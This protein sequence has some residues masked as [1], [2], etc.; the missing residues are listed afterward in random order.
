MLNAIA[1]EEA[2]KALILLDV[3]RAG[4]RN[5]RVAAKQLRRYSD[6]LARC[7]YVELVA[8][9]PA[10]FR[11]V[12]DLVETHRVDYFLDGP[13]D[14]DW[15]FRNHLLE[16]REQIIYVDYVHT[17]EGDEWR[18]PASFDDMSF[19]L[20]SDA[21]DL[22]ASL[23]SLG[24]LTRPGLDAI[25]DAWDGMTLDDDTHWQAVRACNVAVVEAANARSR[26]TPDSGDVKRVVE[27]WGFPLAGLELGTRKVAPGE[28]EAER[29][30]RLAEWAGY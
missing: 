22:V 28:L 16:K 9:R 19:C 6:H 24:C 25:A 10:T 13:N 26:A 3:I 23:R 12:R 7:I 27:T 8:M 15:I 14:V 17:E 21:Q 11:E 5:Q 2:A 20:F 1:E 18:T 29:S 4:W 30:R